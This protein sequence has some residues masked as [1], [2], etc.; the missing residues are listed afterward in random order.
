[1]RG[2]STCLKILKNSLTYL[3]VIH[4]VNR[5]LLGLSRILRFCLN[6]FSFSYLAVLENGW[7][8]TMNAW[9]DIGLSKSDKDHMCKVYGLGS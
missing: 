1:M 7:Q 6:V 9:F 5:L 2:G 8:N 4:Q 3:Q